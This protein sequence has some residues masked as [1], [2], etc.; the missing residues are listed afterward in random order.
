MLGLCLIL[1]FSLDLQMK[2]VKR[3][4]CPAVQSAASLSSHSVLISCQSKYSVR[5][6]CPLTRV[7]MKGKW[8]ILEKY[9]LLLNRVVRL[10]FNWSAIFWTLSTTIDASQSP[11]DSS[12]LLNNLWTSSGEKMSRNSEIVDQG[13]VLFSRLTNNL[14]NKYSLSTVRFSRKAAQHHIWKTNVSSDFLLELLKISQ[15][16]VSALISFCTWR[17]IK[18]SNI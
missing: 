8:L 16:I 6:W 14:K 9:L 5:K 10:T 18:W 12:L 4:E 1:A 2:T 3:S 11:N 7:S 15:V 17:L 13:E